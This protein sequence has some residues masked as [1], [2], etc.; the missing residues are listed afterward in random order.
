MILRV[1]ILFTVIISHLFLAISNI[2][3]LS[4]RLSLIVP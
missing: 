2:S 1:A 3:I 4:L